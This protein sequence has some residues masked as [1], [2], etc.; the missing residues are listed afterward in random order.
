MIIRYTFIILSVINIS[1]FF[2]V[3]FF[4]ALSFLVNKITNKML[5]KQADFFEKSL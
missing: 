1:C 4:T 2:N 3:G 5:P